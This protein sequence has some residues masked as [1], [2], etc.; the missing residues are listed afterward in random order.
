MAKKS[1][2]GFTLIELIVTMTISM[3]LAVIALI[4]FSTLRSQTQFANAVEQTKEF[5]TRQR[6][7]AYSGVELTGGNDKN[8]VFFGRLLTLSG[9]TITT[10]TLVT[11]STEAPTPS[12]TIS[13]GSSLNDI[14]Y[15]IPY[16]ITFSTVRQI[17]FVRSPTDASLHTVTSGTTPNFY[18]GGLRY[19]DFITT[20]PGLPASHYGLTDG[21][22]NATIDIDPITNGV[23]RTFN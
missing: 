13:I 16:G 17:A 18:A 20:L 9:N 12:Q 23:G 19:D 15:T 5:V 4:G 10:Q 21:T 3:G 22:R 14:I 7:E 6:S 1:Q 2:A 11:N 8:N